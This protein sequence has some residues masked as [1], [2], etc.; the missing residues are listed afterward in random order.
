[1]PFIYKGK[2]ACVRLYYVQ[3]CIIMY[4]MATVECGHH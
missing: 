4:R 3:S 2:P 1:M